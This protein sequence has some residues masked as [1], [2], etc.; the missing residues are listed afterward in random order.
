MNFINDEAERCLLA[1]MVMDNSIIENVFMD[2]AENDLA[3]QSNRDIYRAIQKLN[4]QRIGVDIITLSEE[5]KKTVAPV[6]VAELTNVVSTGANWEYYVKLV[7]K[8]SLYRGYYALIENAKAYNPDSDRDITEQITDMSKSLAKLQESAGAER[9]EKTMYQV[10]LATEKKIQYYIKNK[11]NLT[12]YKSGFGRLD[13]YTDGI[14]HNLIII[15]ARPSIGKT[16][17]LETL[18]LNIA[19][20]ND[21]PVALFEIEMTEEQIGLRAISGQANINV[22][23]IK[24][25]RINPVDNKDTH[26]RMSNAMVELSGLKFYLDD[27]TNEIHKIASR[28]RY[29]ARCLGVKVF[30]IDHLSIIDNSNNKKQRHEQMAEIIE[31]LRALKK[32]LNVTIILLAQL[33][34]GAEG[35]K[36]KLS[37]LRETGVAEQSAEDVWMLYRERQVSIEQKMIPTKL[38][39]MKQREGPC[40]DIDLMFNT[41]IVKY[42][43]S[44]A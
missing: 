43:E 27:K 31:I 12:G 25:G 6:V 16:A 26:W 22:R 24:S 39:I 4:S 3:I 21:V 42:F 33:V 15:G 1:S 38:M 41:E 23:H 30:G 34:R 32:E 20:N 44:E 5:T 7:K 11:G 18:L 37:D 9:L 17:L 8:H 36:P 13:Y 40:G 10:M 2:I 14:Q 28:I 19:K 35:E 29:M